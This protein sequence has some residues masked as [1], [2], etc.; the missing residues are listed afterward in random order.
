MTPTTYRAGDHENA[1][2]VTK[3]DLPKWR[4]LLRCLVIGPGMYEGVYY[5]QGTTVLVRE[6][7]LR[8]DLQHGDPKGTQ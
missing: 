2:L 8:E 4:G 6:V 7:E 1:P 3:R 5:E